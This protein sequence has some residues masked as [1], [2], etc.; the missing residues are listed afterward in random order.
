VRWCKVHLGEKGESS[1]EL[2]IKKRGTR[3]K[4][5]DDLIDLITKEGRTSREK[6]KLAREEENL[7]MGGGNVFIEGSGEAHA[8][9]E[10]GFTREQPIQLEEKRGKWRREDVAGSFLRD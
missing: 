4:L 3:Q 2:L 7:V 1:T 5:F 10:A 6:E 9:R 8:C